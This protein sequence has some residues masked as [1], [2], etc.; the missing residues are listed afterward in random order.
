MGNDELKVILANQVCGHVAKA[1]KRM[2]RH[3]LS[4][5]G[6]LNGDVFKLRGVK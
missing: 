4:G 5:W 6:Q 2:F 3:L 1:R